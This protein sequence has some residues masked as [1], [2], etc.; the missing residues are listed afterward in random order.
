MPLPLAVRLASL[1]RAL[2]VAIAAPPPVLQA[3]RLLLVFVLLDYEHLRFYACAAGSSRR[4]PAQH[5]QDAAA[6]RPLR[7]LIAADPQLIDSHTYPH[8]SAPLR[9]IARWASD[10]YARRAWMGASWRKDAVIWAG[11]LTDG[12]RRTMSD[13]ECVCMRRSAVFRWERRLRCYP[14][15]LLTLRFLAGR[16]GGQL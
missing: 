10:T 8:L 16:S 3:L 9:R 12:G 14:V 2:V 1:P 6:V 7:I 5:G 4:S 13:S 15:G 11:D